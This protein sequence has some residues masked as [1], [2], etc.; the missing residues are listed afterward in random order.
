MSRKMYNEDN[1]RSFGYPQ[2]RKLLNGGHP[3]RGALSTDII[4]TSFSP[5]PPPLPASM[6]IFK[7]MLDVKNFYAYKRI[8]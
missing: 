4:R 1:K 7:G 2:N 6:D 8:E 5:P 3:E